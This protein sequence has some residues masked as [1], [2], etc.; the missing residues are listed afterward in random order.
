LHPGAIG[1]EAVF[2]S[3]GKAY[4]ASPIAAFTIHNSPGNY[5]LSKR[6]RECKCRENASAKNYQSKFFDGHFASKSA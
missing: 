3:G 1:V 4:G 2:R 6:L 5:A